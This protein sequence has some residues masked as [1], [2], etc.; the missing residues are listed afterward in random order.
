MSNV[1]SLCSSRSKNK[2]NSMIV[3]EENAKNYGSTLQFISKQDEFPS[4]VKGKNMFA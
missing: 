4:Q 3:Y 2:D 1:T